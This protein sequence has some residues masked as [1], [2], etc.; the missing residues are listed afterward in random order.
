MGR[1]T[2]H[3]TGT[4]Q[5]NKDKTRMWPDA[6][7]LLESVAI[8]KCSMKEMALSKFV[9]VSY[10]CITDYPKTQWPK[11]IVNIY[12]LTDLLKESRSALFGSSGSVSLMRLAQDTGQGCSHLKAW[13]GLKNPRL[14]W[15]TQTA[16]DRRLQSFIT[17][18][19]PQAAWGPSQ[20]GSWL[21][22]EQGIQEE[23]RMSFMI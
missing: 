16:T 23:A 17:W 1:M 6:T 9:L 13:A 21:S 22:P 10:C 2:H 11:I 18:D 19:F 8:R 4:V 7:D 12:Y 15:C 20:H 14:R 3:L 5:Q